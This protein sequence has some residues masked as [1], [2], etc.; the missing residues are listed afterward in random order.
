M[1]E[2]RVEIGIGVSK[3]VE[4]SSASET[5][6]AQ[7]QPTEGVESITDVIPAEENNEMIIAPSEP[8]QENRFLDY[9]KSP[10]VELVVGKG[11][12]Q[13]ILT[14]HQG[15]L[16]SSPYFAELVSQFPED[17]PYQYTG[18]Y[19][20]KRL[21]SLT[22]GLESDPSIPDIDETGDQLL[23]HARVYTLAGK[24]GIDN[25]KSLAQGKIHRINSTAKGEIE[26]AKYVYTHTNP[27]DSIRKPV[28]AFW[29][30][31]SHVLRHEAEEDFRS[32][33]LQYP[34]FGFD[35]L[36][37]VLDQKEKRAN[38]EIDSPG[39]KGSARKRARMG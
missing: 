33:C 3:D 38:R 27:G 23:K 20:P 11:D 37:L 12:D 19:F 25:L 34:Q 36:N 28:A 35:V 9:L 16:T 14:A 1:A 26:Y 10:I 15:I 22:E 13:T 32:L 29:A 7:P 6:A 24:L 17:G 2:P 31:R 21:G 4:M 39:V 18:E 8:T 5:P 30:T